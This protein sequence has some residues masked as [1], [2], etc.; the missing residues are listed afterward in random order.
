MDKTISIQ[1]NGQARN[2]VAG[3]TISDLLGE[4]KIESRYC[5][6]ERNCDVVPRE[7]HA[8][9]QLQ[10]ADTIEVVTLVGGG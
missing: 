2:V 1:L 10:P 9:C 3:M 7:Q 5:A 4:L 6:V 8:Q